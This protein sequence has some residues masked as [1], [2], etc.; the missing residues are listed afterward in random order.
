MQLSM[1]S[2]RR[3]VMTCLLMSFFTLFGVLA[4]QALPVSE[5]PQIDFPTINITASLS[6]ASPETMASAVATPLEGQL[7]TIAGI[8][9][10]SSTSSQGTTKITI[11]FDLD[12]NIDGA[13][14]DVQ[15]AISAAQRK[16]PQNMTSLPSMKKTNPADAPI[17]YIALHSDS[18]PISTVTEYAESK[19]AQSLSMLP[20]VAQ[21]GV[22]G[23]KPYAVR[24]Q[25]DPDKLT[26]HNLG[27]DELATA[28]ANNNVNQPIGDLD[29]AHRSLS[30]QSNGQ[31]ENAAAYRKLVIAYH[32]GAPLYLTEV[33]NVLDS[34]ENTRVA[35]W[36]VNKPGVILAVQRQPG[37]NTI[38]TVDAV[39]KALPQFQ[40]ILPDS[41]HMD[42]LYDR[43]ESIRA[44]IHD[45]QFTL[46]LSC[47]L[48]VL[49][50]WLF[51][52][53]LSA[54]VIPAL[55]VP[56][57]VLGAVPVMYILN[58][59]LDN[60]SLLAL[61][62]AVG[63]VVDDA[64]VMMENIVRHMEEGMPALQAARK[65][66]REI[67]FTILSMTLSL[68]AVFIPLLFMGGL[69]G[70][71]LHEFAVT[72]SAAIAVSGLVS[73]TLTPM[74]CSRV[75]RPQ[76]ETK[77]QGVIAQWLE[78]AFDSLTENYSLS[79]VSALRHPRIVLAVFLA[80]IILSVLLY[81]QLPK[82]FLPSTD[83]GQITLTTK[84]AP[85]TSFETLS[86]M[87]QRVAEII[88]QDPNVAA[89]M[90]SVGSTGPNGSSNGG[91]MTI[92]L[93]PS[94]QRPS[95][96]QVIAELRK[97]VSHIP[98]MNVFLRN[99]PSIRIGGMSTASEYQFTL[100][101]ND[102]DEL[103]LWHDRFLKAIRAIPGL[104]D[105][106]SDQEVVGAGL[107]VKVDR[108]KLASYGLNYS[109]VETTLQ[110]AFAA[111]Q[112]STIYA[113]TNQYA[114]ILE[115]LPEYQQQAADLSRI[116]I[117]NSNGVLISLDTVASYTRQPQTLTVNHLGTLP[118]ATIS[119][120]MRQGMALSDALAALD[121]VKEDL[122]PPATLVTSLQGSAAAFAGSQSGMMVLLLLA[123]LVV[124]GVLG[125]LYESFVHP[126]TILSGLP[127]AGLGALVTLWLFQFPITLYA[128][129]G[130]LLLIGI[131][132]KNA[133]MMIDFAL[134]REREGMAPD[135]AIHQ[136]CLI[137]FRPIM[138]T[139]IAALAGALPIA[140]GLGAGA[141]L[142]QPLGV[143]I[144]GGLLLSQVVTLYL[145]PVIY[146]Y[147]APWHAKLNFR[148]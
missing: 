41:I 65:G 130:I 49:V 42:I 93:V 124:Y 81:Q 103:K 36:F 117:R 125:M 77:E 123:L 16:L 141:E 126:L 53:N 100:Q 129:V 120:N 127:S 131:V 74:L 61:T 39:K 113:D 68:V 15:S 71:L 114:V 37:A 85:D 136:A 95:A 7:A 132:K 137:R 87:Q 89:F 75:L 116:R 107:A 83:S 62:L 14:L 146:H 108:D 44:S 22:Y 50:I 96:D 11:Q 35:S 121:K 33:A 94:N 43:S 1:L 99:P 142:R 133:I 82:D 112:V 115:V 45:V 26:A 91:S 6:G 109:Q 46:L 67:G 55:A 102:F 106:T 92:R 140:L 76:H 24:I 32:N 21:V 38:S 64:I 58:Y 12:R 23:A 101:S 80:S 145:T 25:A 18:L 119:F 34:E 31:L 84:A 4:Y 17:F 51:L 9:N 97:K 104:M 139:S 86:R 110:S 118:A 2:I 60:L 128:F 144:V 29:G 147:L 3:P 72:I 88:R 40:A 48:V 148:H 98:G 20:G 13:A 79:L 70:R 134:E 73:L 59:S 135:Q 57:S 52:R 111:R 56:L 78:R 54:T 30:L 122:L 8:D 69:M 143:A 28:V 63:F 10:I 5:L 66:A 90:S 27:L 47:A 19:L 138:M 105:V